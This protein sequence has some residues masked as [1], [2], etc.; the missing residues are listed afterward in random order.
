MT[1]VYFAATA[2]YV[3]KARCHSGIAKS[4][5][6]S[7]RTA[8]RYLETDRKRNPKHNGP[9]NQSTELHPAEIAARDNKIIRMIEGSHEWISK[10][11]KLDMLAYR[12]GKVSPEYCLLTGVDIGKWGEDLL[13][14]SLTLLRPSKRLGR[15]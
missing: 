7:R 2:D 11:G 1:E 4:F 8:C 5:G 15:G 10:G 12:S 14:I 9:V 13:A 3:K 6:I